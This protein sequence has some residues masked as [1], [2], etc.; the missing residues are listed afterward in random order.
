MP[1]VVA[2]ENGEADDAFDQRRH[3]RLAEFLA[4][5]DEVAFPVSELLAIGDHVRVAQNVDIRA[6]ALAMPASGM[7]RAPSCTMFRQ[8]PPELDGM[9]VRRIG[10]FVDRLLA[11][12]DRVAFQPHPARDLLRRPAMHDPLDDGLT[13]MR[14]AGK[15]PQLGPAFASHLMRCHAMA[16]AEIWPLGEANPS[17]SWPPCRVGDQPRSCKWAM[18]TSAGVL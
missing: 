8:V 15:L 3:I 5:L 18:N 4:E 1:V 14:E 9:S 12:G 11:D 16:T 17:A 7:A 13:D 2:Q 10:E 6:E